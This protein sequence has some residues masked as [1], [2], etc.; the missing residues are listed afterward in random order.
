MHCT[1][2][3]AGTF[4]E[5][6]S[7]PEQPMLPATDYLASRTPHKGRNSGEELCDG[8]N[9]DYKESPVTVEELLQHGEESS[10][11]CNGV[12]APLLPTSL[13]VCSPLPS[14]FL[15]LTRQ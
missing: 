15:Q 13:C 1:A 11:P 6:L 2:G 5:L 3:K 8:L 9:L 7:H 10:D 12:T 4:N 14:P